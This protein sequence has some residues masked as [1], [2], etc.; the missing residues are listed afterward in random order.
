MFGDFGTSIIRTVTPIV[1]G[2]IIAFFASKGIKLDAQASDSL[3]VFLQ[4]LFT[5]L[6]YICVR[7][8]EAR[9]PKAGLL[10]GSRK[11]PEYTSSDK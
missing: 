11:T 2:A 10:L 8:L 1:V 5:G 7:L 3:A 9:F 6:Y 4:A